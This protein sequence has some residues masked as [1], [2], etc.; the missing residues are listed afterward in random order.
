MEW[1]IAGG[2]S[3]LAAGI[4][5]SVAHGYSKEIKGFEVRRAVC[6]ERQDRDLMFSVRGP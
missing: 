6:V 1:A 5:W 3:G 2:V 4:L